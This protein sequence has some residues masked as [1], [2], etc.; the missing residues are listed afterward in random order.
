MQE[1]R[2]RMFWD[3]LEVA[4]CCEPAREEEGAKVNGDS[5]KFPNIEG[6]MNIK[7]TMH[8]QV[9]YSVT[10]RRCKIL[11]LLTNSSSM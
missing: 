2:S 3:K 10:K 9:C 8:K 5:G 7:K 6:K 1:P 11:S 4:R